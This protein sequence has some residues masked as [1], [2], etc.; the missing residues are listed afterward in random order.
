MGI[1]R[2]ETELLTNAIQGENK[3]FGLIVEKYQSLICA[4]TLSATNNLEKSEELAQQVFVNAWQNLKQLRDVTKFRSW[5]CAIARNVINHALRTQ[6]RDLLGRA[7]P[8]DEHMSVES[9]DKGPAE[10]ISLQEQQKIVA[11]AFSNL[12]EAYRQV[13]VLFYREEK[14]IQKVAEQLALSEV[15]VKTRLSRGRQ[16]LREHIESTI[17]KTLISTK[18]GKAFTAAVMV[19]IAG[20]GIGSANAAQVIGA[21]GKISAVGSGAAVSIIAAKIFIIAASVAIIGGGIF[22]GYKYLASPDNATQKKTIVQEIPQDIVTEQNEQKESS[23]VAAADANMQ[24]SVVSSII[25]ETSQAEQPKEEIAAEQQQSAFEPKGVLSGL[26]TDVKTGMPVKDAMVGITGTNSYDE[27]HVDANGFY[28][29]K[30]AKGG[31]GIYRIMVDSTDYVGITDWA[32]YPQIELKN[33]LSQVKHFALEKACKLAIKVTDQRDKPIKGAKFYFGSISNP[34]NKGAYSSRVMTDANGFAIVGG[35]PPSAEPYQIVAVRYEK[36]GIGA[37]GQ[38]LLYVPGHVEVTLM[39]PDIVPSETIELEDGERIHGQ[40]L[41]EDG[42]PAG[43]LRI[44]VRPDWWRLNLR[45]IEEKI[46]P[47]GNFEFV[48]TA[49]GRYRAN[50]VIP[51]QDD[52]KVIGGGMIKTLPDVDLP[53]DNNLLIVTIP[54]KSPQNMEKITGKMRFVNGKP[55]YVNINAF[56]RKNPFMQSSTSIRPDAEEAEFTIKR[57]ESGIY[58]VSFG[59]DVESKAIEDVKVPGPDIDVELT[60]ISERM[61]NGIVI[62]AANKQPVKNFRAR[63]ANDDFYA[64][65]Q[66]HWDTWVDFFTEDGKFSLKP[67]GSGKLFY[68]EVTDGNGWGKT[69][70]INVDEQVVV[71]LIKSGSVRGIVVD[72]SGK[73]IDGVSVTAASQ[74]SVNWSNSIK[75]VSQTGTTKTAKGGVFTIHNLPCGKDSLKATHPDY[76]IAEVGDIEIKSGQTTEDIK[77]VLNRGGTVEGYIYDE[78]GEP[79]AGSILR[80]Y[81]NI[82]RQGDPLATAVTDENG[83]YQITNLP[84]QMCVADRNYFNEN[85]QGVI[86]R[87]FMPSKSGPVRLDFG[88]EPVVQGKLSLPNEENGNRKLIL[89]S[90][91]AYAGDFICTCLTGADGRFSFGGIPAGKYNI[92]IKAD[93][94]LSGERKLASIMTSGQD[95]DLGVIPDQNT[96]TLTVHL[97]HAEGISA[98][99]LIRYGLDGQIAS[100]TLQV[101]DTN[102]PQV[103]RNLPD[104]D[105]K[106][107]TS[108]QNG[109]NMT[110]PVNGL[111]ADE[112]RTIDFPYGNACVHGKITGDPNNQLYMIS[113]DEIISVQMLPTKDGSYIVEN[114]PSGHY[115]IQYTKNQKPVDLTE[116]DLAENSN[117]ALDLHAPAVEPKGFLLVLVADANGLPISDADVFIEQGSNIYTSK[118]YPG[119]GYS[120]QSKPGNYILKVNHNGRIFTRNVTVEKRNTNSPS[121]P[122]VSIRLDK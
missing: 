93:N 88:G 112:I 3:A 114:L 12:P 119:M 78:A 75:Q 16:M 96:G 64:D 42:M 102:A 15:A 58:H 87:N 44:S 77:I 31:D 21:G 103:F 55:D 74:I 2:N 72:E 65:D 50:V 38:R 57:L 109:F 80:I 82:D 9:Q 94:R 45:P 14:S 39:N 92:Y 35:I 8:M 71:E 24:Q 37:Y 99:H 120:I 100:Q 67:I 51:T 10:K 98:L 47:N 117:L 118:G 36:D 6:E 27:K 83:F 104:G 76:S 41:Y 29:F 53:P 115:K 4:I 23:A 40:A 106:I 89:S 33:D 85:V 34:P 68:V 59:G 111:K 25:S 7:M 46:D 61:L 62:G 11:S 19:S 43:D 110:I 121:I 30:K 52:P 84:E 20:I 28:S 108:R 122:T 5:L 79:I 107:I 66:R 91:N 86:R 113:A 56:S 81:G 73:G 1:Y 60:C 101:T 105:Y 26:V 17:E 22:V 116:F 54:M 13:L 70:K 90:C 63:L 48:H 18:P 95:Q 69:G 49:A 97:Q 32:E